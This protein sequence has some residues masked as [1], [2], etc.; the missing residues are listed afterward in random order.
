MRTVDAAPAHTMDLTGVGRLFDLA[1][2][3]PDVIRE[4]DDRWA[5][6][7]TVCPVVDGP[8]HVGLTQGPAASEPV[9][10]MER[11]TYTTEA[12]LP[13]AEPIVVPVSADPGRA[14]TASSVRAL[15]VRPGQCLALARGVWHAPAMGL[16]AASHYYWLAQ[17]DPDTE[18]VWSQIEDGPVWIGGDW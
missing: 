8:A 18:S 16:D 13:A 11:H 2:S 5:G 3:S 7:Y 12:L 1:T 15:I 14:P 10:C 4:R 9:V 17:V 6:G